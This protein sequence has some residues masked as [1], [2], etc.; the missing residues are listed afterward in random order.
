MV[1]CQKQFGVPVVFY[2]SVS[3]PIKITYK[4]P[5]R[6]MSPYSRQQNDMRK[7]SGGMTPPH[8]PRPGDLAGSCGRTGQRRFPAENRPQR[9]GTRT[10]SRPRRKASSPQSDPSPQLWDL[11]TR[12]VLNS[13]CIEIRENIKIFLETS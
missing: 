5:Y 9:R 3:T 1:W 4:S 7:P 6:S 10:W 12:P 2:D 11:N 13:Q 8:P